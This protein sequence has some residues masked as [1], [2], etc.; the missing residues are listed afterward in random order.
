VIG[1]F[2]SIAQQADHAPFK[3]D[4]EQRAQ[5]IGLAV[6]VAREIIMILKFKSAALIS[7]LLATTACVTDP[8]T[9]NRRISKAAI[10]GVGGAG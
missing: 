1:R 10:G 6:K 5:V 4:A 3:P 2:L 9:G 8:T 7:G